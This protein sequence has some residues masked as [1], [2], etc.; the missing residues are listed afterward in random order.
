ME[1]TMHYEIQYGPAYALAVV[2]LDEGEKFR[3][4]AGAMVT[5]SDSIK[6]E[7][8]G[9][10]SL[11]SILRRSLL[12]GE[13]LFMN[14][15]ISTQAGSRL[16]LA[17]VLPGD[18]VGVDITAGRDLLVQ[19][20]SYMASTADVNVDTQFGA[21]K[22]FFSGEGLFLLKLTGPGLTL[23]SSYGAIVPMELAAGESHVVDSGHIVA[24][25]AGMGYE[26]KKAGDS[27]KTTLVGGE[28]LVAR[29]TG[30]GRMWFQTRS[31]GGFIQWLLPRLP[32]KSS[33]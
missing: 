19:S 9:G 22:T 21:G 27:W 31:P 30:P 3:S 24:F 25:D 16:T 14:H 1:V 13:S 23:L 6:I 5:M 28:G 4:E 20:G 32:N 2:T 11:G 18:I 26:V 33:N 12:G 17:P 10:G 15:M 29:I 8:K 7:T